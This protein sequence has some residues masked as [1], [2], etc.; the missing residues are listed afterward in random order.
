MKNINVDKP[1]R[2]VV[3]GG[4]ITGL[5]AAWYLQE[6]SQQKIDIVQNAIHVAQRLGVEQP[7]VAILAATE[8]VNPK[9]PTTLDAA[10][11]SKMADRGQI[12]G[13]LID[14]PLA[15]DNA[16]S[17]ESAQIK[18]I[19]G[20]AHCVVNTNIAAWEVRN[21]FVRE[22]QTDNAPHGGLDFGI[23]GI[24]VAKVTW[25]QGRERYRFLAGAAPDWPAAPG[26]FVVEEV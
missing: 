15:L 7:K 19:K 24:E 9:I 4:G 3:I 22:I 23:H 12:K 6:H 1:K 13:G 18:G 8:M 14:G 20:E 5:S 26:N 25:Q 21:V 16:I 2:A 10:N 17:P 11:L